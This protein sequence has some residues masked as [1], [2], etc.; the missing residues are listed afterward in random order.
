MHYCSCLGFIL[1]L[2]AFYHLAC[3]NWSLKSPRS[4]SR[5]RYRCWSYGGFR[6]RCRSSGRRCGGS[7]NPYFGS[8][9]FCLHG[10]FHTGPSSGFY[11]SCGYY[12]FR[13]YCC[14]NY[15]RLVMSLSGFHACASFN[16]SG[17]RRCV[18]RRP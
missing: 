7:G 1:C 15:S 10:C 18:Y 6:F 5:L 17:F 3:R 2:Y 4:L 8:R 11:S 12:S 9:S 14:W 16:C 13:Y